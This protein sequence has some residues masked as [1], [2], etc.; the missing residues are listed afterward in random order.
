MFRCSLETE[1]GFVR[2]AHVGHTSS[3][4]EVVVE[5][6][7]QLPREAEAEVEAEPGLGY[8]YPRLH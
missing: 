5:E 8:W 7:E 4:S 6:A 2:S 3:A 1:L